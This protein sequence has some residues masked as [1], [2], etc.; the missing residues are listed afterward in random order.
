[1]KFRS[2]C[3]L[4]FVLLVSI[5]T[6]QTVANNAP[7]TIAQQMPEYPGGKDSLLNDILRRVVYPKTCSDSGI[8]GKVYLRFVVNTNGGVSDYEVIK[9]PHP[10][11]GNAAI[12]AAQTLKK[13]APGMHDGKPVRVWVSVPV[14]FKIKVQELPPPPNPDNLIP[15]MDSATIA[16]LQDL[17][18]DLDD[19][20][21]DTYP[22]FPGGDVAF[23]EFLARNLNYPELER[24]NDIQGKVLVRFVVTETGSIES[25]EITQ[26]LTIGLNSEAIRIVKMLPR[27]KPATKNGKPVRTYFNMPFV[28]ALK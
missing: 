12:E 5:V 3:I 21:L 26:G 23:N 11:L 10:L 28:F 4:A 7:L 2:L 19:T 22:E 1:M 16:E 9:T 18:K 15:I 8:Q 27:F 6:A 14:T 13:F 17:V 20:P 24:D 25:I